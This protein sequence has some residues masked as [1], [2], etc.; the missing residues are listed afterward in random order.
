MTCFRIKCKEI[1]SLF[2][3]TR[4][5]NNLQGWE[6]QTGVGRLTLS[7]GRSASAGSC[8]PGCHLLPSAHFG[9]NLSLACQYLSD[10]QHQPS[11]IEKLSEEPLAQSSSRGRERD[12]WGAGDSSKHIVHS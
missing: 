4:G 12:P 5:K 1:A 9:G 8:P 3:F 11:E 10:H 7:G 2:F 6:E